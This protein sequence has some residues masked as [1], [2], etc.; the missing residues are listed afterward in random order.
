MKRWS[1]AYSL[2]CYVTLPQEY[3][4]MTV[5]L[6]DYLNLSNVYIFLR[7]NMADNEWLVYIHLLCCAL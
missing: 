5:E 3:L 1:L 7:E 6:P 4:R 2:A